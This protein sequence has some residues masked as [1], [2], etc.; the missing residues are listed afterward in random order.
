[1][2]NT[3]LKK[4][5]KLESL[6]LNLQQECIQDDELNSFQ[7]GYQQL[8]DLIPNFNNMSIYEKYFHVVCEQYELSIKPNKQIRVLKDFLYNDTISNL[9]NLKRLELDLSGNSIN[10]KIAFTICTVIGRFKMLTNL[11]LQL[12]QFKLNNQISDVGVSN[13]G[14]GISC[15]LNLTT[16]TLNIAKNQFGNEGAIYIGRA[17]SACQQ[18]TYLN[19]N[20]SQTQIED[21][22][23]S[24]ISAGLSRCQLLIYLNLQLWENKLSDRGVQ[25]IGLGI[26]NCPQLKNLEFSII[27]NRFRIQETF[28]FGAILDSCK[29]LTNLKID[30]S[31]NQ[32]DKYTSQ[33]LQ[34]LSNYTQF[35]DQ[36]LSDNQ[37]IGDT[38]ASQIQQVQSSCTHLTSL[39]FNISTNQ[40]GKE[41]ASAIGR[42]LS[43]YQL[44]TNLEFILQGNNICDVGASQIGQGL[45][46]CTYLTNLYFDMS[47]N[48]IGNEGASAIGTAL[49][50]YKLITNLEL[51][52][53]GNKIGDKGAS[54]IGQDLSS[55]TY[56][57]KLKFNMSKNSI[58]NE[59]A[60]AIGTALSNYKLI[61]NLE[62]ILCKNSI[63]NEGASA[64]GRALSNY[65]LLTNLSFYLSQNNI[66]I[67]GAE[68]IGLGLSSCTHL[69]NL[70]FDMGVNKIGNKGASAIGRA[71]SKFKLLTNLELEL[72]ICKFQNKGVSAI[73]RALSSCKLL[74]NLEL[75]LLGNE[76]G[77]V[78]ASQ[79]EQGLSSCSHLT[80]LKFDMAINKIGNEGACAIGRALRSQK[81][82]T[83]LELNLWKNNIGD[84]GA[85]QIGQGL[86]S[87]TH[88]T[89]LQFDMRQN[90]IGIE[91]AEQI[92][93]GLSSCTHLTDLYFNMSKNL[94]GD[95]GA[96]AIGRALSNYKLLTNLEFYLWE[97]KIGDAGASQIAQGLS[98]CTHLKNLKFDM[99]YN[100]FGNEKA[101]AI[102][103]ALIQ[104]LQVIQRLALNEE[105]YKSSWDVRI[106]TIGMI[107]LFYD[108]V[109]KILKTVCLR[110]QKGY[111]I[112]KVVLS[113]I[114]VIFVIVMFAYREQNT[115][116][117][118][119]SSLYTINLCQIHQILYNKSNIIIKSIINYAFL[120][121]IVPSSYFH[122]WYYIYNQD[123]E[124]NGIYIGMIF[125]YMGAVGI[126]IFLSFKTDKLNRIILNQKCN[127]LK[128]T[129]QEHDE[130]L[131]QKIQSN[132]ALNKKQKTKKLVIIVY[133]ILFQFISIYLNTNGA[134]IQ[135]VFSYDAYT[136]LVIIYSL[137]IVLYLPLVKI[138]TIE[139]G[140][141]IVVIINIILLFLK[142]FSGPYTI[143]I[144]I[145]NINF[146][147]V[148]AGFSQKD[149]Y[150][151]LSL[152]FNF[153]SFFFQNFQ[154]KRMY[155]LNS[156][157]FVERIDK[158]Y[159]MYYEPVVQP[160]IQI[161]FNLLYLAQFY[162]S[163]NENYPYCDLTSEFWQLRILTIAIISLFYD[164]VFFL[165]RK[166]CQ[167]YQKGYLIAKL[168]LSV[169]F[170]AFM[171][172]LFAAKLQKNAIVFI[173]TSLYTINLCQIHSIL[174][175]K[176]NVII[177][178]I[179]N[180]ALLVLIVPT[181]YLCSFFYDY[182]G[183][184][185]YNGIYVGMIFCYMGAIGIMILL[186]FKTDKLRRIN[187]QQQSDEQIDETLLQKIQSNRILNKKQQ[188]AKCVIFVYS[189]L[190]QFISIYLNTNG[191]AIQEVFT[192]NAFSTSAIIYSLIIVLY[193]PLVKL[194]TIED[195]VNILV[196]LN[197]ILLFI[198]IFTGL[199]TIDIFNFPINTS[200]VVAGFS[201]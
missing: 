163:V 145:F 26:R 180:Y 17:L 5:C 38:V 52:L 75:I 7:V 64:I 144:F 6:V 73:G 117:F 189:I 129:D 55:Y 13:I 167:R 147:I 2:L 146:S 94:I 182:K 153:I 79:I 46:S 15:C 196:V 149:Q 152:G 16:L 78:E 181:S 135:E 150:M 40:I 113:V 133:S 95:Q 124:I 97:N 74:T 30:L 173:T 70:K 36:E 22:G 122:N 186:S 93:L 123:S 45:S 20:L 58:G 27:K 49:S 148:V 14:V 1:M 138:V 114:F 183:L 154:F 91:G 47:K 18:L 157:D 23:A 168:A 65:K 194:V 140:V 80:N 83:N 29:L 106:L 92:G 137:L 187:L 197:I 162:L 39:K 51:I 195:G 179:L 131:L 68:Q 159:L 166:I 25:D 161:A 143:Q 139:D 127:N 112:I 32:G 57:T 11:N 199:Y 120:V 171:I 109:F 8:K 198:K 101:S 77:D 184:G 155:F 119:T 176:S 200:I 177:K 10:D 107:S 50:N 81:L 151:R 102:G 86:S 87:C 96:S 84:E 43:K 165:L 53:W 201:Q 103:R 158:D 34:G 28:P 172:I 164:F 98:S 12:W 121:L 130:T 111:L 3:S 160:S 100:Q 116:V 104:S 185:S 115:I 110:F 76:I 191:A 44:L 175:N 132:R 21:E 72:G 126:L 62:L 33:I 136:T 105:N 170:I 141:N 193:L 61:T 71:L 90:K 128:L 35:K 188:T 169:I 134:A 60:S 89:K 69:T 67:A 37:I 125:C 48:S 178:C 31:M 85:S 24:A 190:F 41:G 156:L 118:I 19:I 192:Y 82:L 42:A 88:L 108:L 56:L 99:G 66:C 9:A 174:Y 59:G 63:G 4:C 54:Q 142:M